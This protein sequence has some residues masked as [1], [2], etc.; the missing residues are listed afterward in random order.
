MRSVFFLTVTDFGDPN[1]PSP[2]NPLRSAFVFVAVLCGLVATGRAESPLSPVSARA[3]HVAPDRPATLE[4]NRDG[5]GSGPLDYVVRGYRG[6]EEARG[7][8]EIRAGVVR[9]E[10]AFP[11]GF[12]EIEFPAA[13]QR[14]GVLALPKIEGTPDPFFAMDAAASWLVDDDATRDELIAFAKSTG[15][16]MIRERVSWRAI[17]P[18]ADRWDWR[19]DRRYEQLRQSYRRAGIP[20]LEMGHDAPAWTGLVAKYP[21]DLVATA[22]SWRAISQRWGA[23]WGGVELWNEPDIGFGGDLPGDQYSAYGKAVAYGLRRASTRAPV[24]GGVIALYK[25][26]F[27]A[28]CAESGLLDRVDAFS[29]H[30]YGPALAFEGLNARYRE[31][32]RAAGKADMPLWITECGWPWRKGPAR[33]PVD[34]DLAS[35]SNIVMKAVEA[36]ACG[37]ERYF[38]FVYPYYEENANNFSVMD[39]HATPLRG[40]AAYAQAIQTLGGKRYLGD[41]KLDDPRIARARVFGDDARAVAVLY[42]TV[43]EAELRR[44]ID[45]GIAPVRVEAADGRAVATTQGRFALV[46][47]LAYAWFDRATIATKL[48]PKTRAMGLHPGSNVPGAETS[49]IVLRYRF[50]SAVVVPESAGYRLKRDEA[51]VIPVVVDVANLGDAAETLD[52]SL[53]VEPGVAVGS[54]SR[55]VQVAPRSLAAATWRADLSGSFADFAPARFRVEARGPDGVRDRLAFAIAG[56]PTLEAALAKLP[57]HV[58]LPIED[59]SRWSD[60]IGP[61]GTMTMTTGPGGWKL[62]VRHAPDTDRWAYPSFRL[63]DSVDLSEA[64]GL[65]LRARCRAAADVRVFVWEGESGVG[66]INGPSLIPADG[67]WHVAR[68][69]FDALAASSANAPDPNGELDLKRARRLGLGLNSHVDANELEVSD[70]TVAW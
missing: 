37:V 40:M 47:G 64:R 38:T 13:S 39:G 67:R 61:G 58:R 26:P 66:Y 28:A 34:Q 23:T 4:W 59:R 69:D 11:R 31:W 5:G 62:N 45:L 1:G 20:V 18:A 54:A 2:R 52:V 53:T 43:P 24:V 63:P 46:D 6:E 32:L 7:K 3:F 51:G 55:R 68:I 12:H 9:I 14:F 29:F 22:D 27:L 49:P 57:R 56:E 21:G 65:V 19:A 42:S 48:D 16:A 15:L 50:D 44:P 17:Q 8:A 33:P 35:A 30:N 10:R 60:N 36:R 25:P 41:L 70:L